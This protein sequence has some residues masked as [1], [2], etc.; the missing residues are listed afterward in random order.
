[1]FQGNFIIAL[2]AVA[3]QGAILPKLVK[4]SILLY[5]FPIG[6]LGYGGYQCFVGH[7]LMQG[8]SKFWIYM[9][10]ALIQLVIG[11]MGRAEVIE[12]NQVKIS[13]K[14]FKD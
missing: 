5:I 13:A 11:L 3:I 14:E 10:L 12:K 2:I 6:T 8:L 1:M 9:L 7:T 4:W